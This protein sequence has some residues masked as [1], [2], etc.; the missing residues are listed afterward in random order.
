MLAP[1]QGLTNHAMRALFID[2]VRPDVVFT[3]FMRV[4]NVSRKHLTRRDLLEA[5][6]TTKEVPLV[7]Q[8]VGNQEK[9]L[10]TAARN[11]EAAG[12]RHINLN[13]GCPYGRMTT[14]AT[15]GAMLQQPE[16]LAEIIPALRAAI[17][18][19]FSIKLR[20]GYNDPEQ[21]FTLLPLFSSASVDFLI[22]HPRSVVQKYAGFAD[23]NITA[24]VVKKT[25]IPVIANGDIRTAAEGAKV[26]QETGAA[27][28]MLGR[29]AIS[30]PRLFEMIRNRQFDELGHAETAAMLHR[31]LNDLLSR[32][33]ALFCG[34]KQ[35]LDKF[36][37]VLVF[38]EAR[39]FARHINKMKRVK[40]IAGMSE[41]IE[42]LKQQ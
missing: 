17:S 42:E 24:R 11:A 31:Y 29:G 23:H 8:L 16:Q 39:S 9:A 35:I 38:I 7:A 40:S 34:E 13:L 21:I 6:T 41:M 5:T 2:W 22:L 30:N 10:V 25:M 1:L 27:G 3:E 18:G 33:S 20:A 28:L 4:S 15:G 37:N 12:V 32:Y 26:L 36:K 14:G 19:S